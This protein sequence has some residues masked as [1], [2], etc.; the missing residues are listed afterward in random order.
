MNVLLAFL[1]GPSSKISSMRVNTT[2]IVFL[3]MSVWTYVSVRK[4]E[5]Q[6]FS[7]FHV[8]ALLGAMGLKAYQKKVENDAAKLTSTVS[9]TRTET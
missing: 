4:V 1:A 2:L 7:E 5:L 8:V 3:I 9:V 6:P